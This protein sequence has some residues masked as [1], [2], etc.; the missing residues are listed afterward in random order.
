M[1]NSGSSEFDKLYKDLPGYTQE[2]NVEQKTWNPTIIV[3]KLQHQSFPLCDM[4]KTATITRTFFRDEKKGV[5]KTCNENL[6]LDS[7]TRQA[8]LDDKKCEIIECDRPAAF[9][10]KSIASTFRLCGVHA[11]RVI[12]D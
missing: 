6:N 5:C 4:C 12:R 2:N 3:T 11:A 9:K 10:I 1:G 8:I 7:V